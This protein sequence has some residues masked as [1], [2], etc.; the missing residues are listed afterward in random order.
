M[1]TAVSVLLWAKNGERV[2][3]EEN[4]SLRGKNNNNSNETT[5]TTTP[6]KCSGGSSSSSRTHPIV[7]LQVFE[8]LHE[9][10]VQP[11]QSRRLP[12]HRNPRK[13]HPS[14]SQ[15]V[16]HL[17]KQIQRRLYYLSAC[18]LP[19]PPSGGAHLANR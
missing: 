6:T 1:R 5:I 14:A 18:P 10:L 7:Q 16:V 8:V 4:N 3:V 9:G 15:Q 13:L 17:R 11:Q 19:L 2:R 12:G